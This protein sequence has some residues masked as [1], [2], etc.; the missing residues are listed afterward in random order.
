MANRYGNDDRP[1]SYRDPSQNPGDHAMGGSQYHVAPSFF[2]AFD[3][4][5]SFQ[6]PQQQTGN[7]LL[8]DV[9]AFTNIAVRLLTEK[10]QYKQPGENIL[11][12]TL[13]AEERYLFSEAYKLKKG[14]LATFPSPGESSHDSLIRRLANAFGDSLL[15]QIEYPSGQQ[16]HQQSPEWMSQPVRPEYDL[17]TQQLQMHGY[18][19][20]KQQ[21]APQQHHFQRILT[22]QSNQSSLQ[23]SQQQRQGNNDEQE[24]A[25][26]DRNMVLSHRRSYDIPQDRGS[27]QHSDRSRRERKSKSPV[28][29]RSS[30][31]P[32]RKEIERPKPPTPILKKGLD[33][34]HSVQESVTKVIVQIPKSPIR[35]GKGEILEM[36][37]LKPIQSENRMN[38]SHTVLAE[39]KTRQR[40]MAEIDQTST[41]ASH[42]TNQGDRAKYRHHLEGLKIQL[43]TFT[44]AS[45]VSSLTMHDVGRRNKARATRKSTLPPQEQYYEIDAV[46][47]AETPKPSQPRHGPLSGHLQRPF[48]PIMEMED[49][50]IPF[51]NPSVAQQRRRRSPGKQVTEQRDDRPTADKISENKEVPNSINFDYNLMDVESVFTQWSEEKPVTTLQNGE[52]PKCAFVTDEHDRTN[53]QQNLEVDTKKDGNP[54]SMKVL[55]PGNLPENFEFEA[56]VEGRSFTARVP[57]GG[58]RKGEVFETTITDWRTTTYQEKEIPRHRWKDGLFDCFGYGLDHPMLWNSFLFPQSKSWRRAWFTHE[59]HC[60]LTLLF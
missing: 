25:R 1:S 51:H 53:G 28:R 5:S 3:A 22:D 59:I 43:E 14:S 11:Q 19:V 48:S 29:R 50:G 8:H 10:D 37:P 4:E 42:S 60:Q 49:F 18:N 26:S 38:Q 2:G 35:R 40:L 41:L 21:A 57:K 13:T 44:A 36:L 27:F 6:Q 54:G 58:A 45:S 17:S 56:E 31:S 23:L 39:S 7:P 46:L 34:K 30:R 47:Y 12:T 16:S 9:N 55:S 32:S 24:A 20:Y 15:K 33:N 52:K